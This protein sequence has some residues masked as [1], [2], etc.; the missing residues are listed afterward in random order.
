[1]GKLLRFAALFLTFLLVSTAC[2]YAQQTE[3]A[4]NNGTGVKLKGLEDIADKRIGIFT[5]TVHDA[6][7]ADHY[8]KA[9]PFRYDMTSDMVLSLKTGKID[10]IMLDLITANLL[11][12]RNPEL[13]IL[14]DKVFDMPVGVGF[15]KGDPGLRSE[16]NRFLQAI[17][18]NGVYEEMRNR[19]LV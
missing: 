11:I 4:G 15:K 9:K 18:K 8:P 7:L 6:Y 5:G 17:R 13:A 19:W 10:V 1:M 16:F 3:Q 12:K 14:S 2:S